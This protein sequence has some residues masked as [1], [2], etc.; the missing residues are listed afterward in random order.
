MG[1]PFFLGLAIALAVL[2][3]GAA[4]LVGRARTLLDRILA[5]DL[6]TTTLVAL[7]VTQSVSDG[8]GHAIDAALVLATLAFVGTLASAR[9]LRRHPP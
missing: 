3:G 1:D 4:L 7:L 9:Y 5:F 6:A 2:F 8:T